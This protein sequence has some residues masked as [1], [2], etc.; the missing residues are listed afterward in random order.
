MN[1]FS[2]LTSRAFAIILL[3]SVIVSLILKNKLPD[4][5]YYVFLFLP[6]FLVLSIAFCIVRRYLST[7]KRD[8][9]F[10][11]SMIFHLGIL[12]VIITTSLSYYFNFQATFVLP[13]NISVDLNNKKF[14]TIHSLPANQALPFMVLKLNW[15]KTQYVGEGFPVDFVAEVTVGLMEGVTFNQSTEI[16]RVNQPINKGGYQFL[17]YKELYAPM[18]TLR[19]SSGDIIFNGFLNLFILTKDEDKF[20]VPNTELT[21]HTRFFPDMFVENGRYGTRSRELNNPAFG[22]KI[23]SEK[24]PFTKL[25]S[26]VLKSGERATFNGQSLEFEELKQI[27]I[28]QVSKE[29]TY[30]GIFIGWIFIVGGLIL[31][32]VSFYKVY[33]IF[34]FKNKESGSKEVKL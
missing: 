7:T 24:D 22:V 12:V 31:R 32:Y 14:S 16:V 23:Y 29:P 17:L 34:S 21:L 10:L 1:F 6:I 13:E 8:V 5:F 27:V 15:Q 19:D 18:F 3:C 25:W 20:K 26:G 28:M 30:W 9:K 2:A 33:S 4:F 11:G